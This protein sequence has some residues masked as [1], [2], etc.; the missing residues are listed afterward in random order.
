M[1]RKSRGHGA[2]VKSVSLTRFYLIMYGLIQLLAGMCELQVRL[3]LF[4]G[5]ATVL[6]SPDMIRSGAMVTGA[7]TN[8]EHVFPFLIFPPEGLALLVSRRD[9]NA[10]NAHV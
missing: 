2:R 6:K 9:A 7:F 3:N 5:W 10:S 1:P 4:G 8:L